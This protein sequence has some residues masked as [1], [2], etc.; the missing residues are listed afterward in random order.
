MARFL[1]YSIIISATIT[2]GLLI[3]Y[4]IVFINNGQ[5]TFYVQYG[6]TEIRNKAENVELPTNEL[7]V[8]ECKNSMGLGAEYNVKIFFA[9]KF[10]YKVNNVLSSSSELDDISDNFNLVKNKDFFTLFIDKNLTVEK[11]LKTFYSGKTVSSVPS[12]DLT[13]NDYFTLIVT[14]ANNEKDI[15]KISFH[16]GGV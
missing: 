7:L 2:I 8:F 3:A 11:I 5:K 4:L 14:S 12:V 6:E 15:I 1:K 13:K 16:L 9:E 10:E